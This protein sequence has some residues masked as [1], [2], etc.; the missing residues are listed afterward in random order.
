MEFDSINNQPL[1][2]VPFGNV[3]MQYFTEISNGSN[4][5]RADVATIQDFMDINGFGAM[6]RFF[7]SSSMPSY[8]RIVS[9]ASRLPVRK[10]TREQAEG[11][12][13][14]L[15]CHEKYKEGDTVKTLPCIHYFHETCIGMSVLRI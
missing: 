7:G 15:I 12:K 9:V 8:S 1:S 3:L 6:P 2:S 14:C 5:P 10:I 4:A 11:G 13:K